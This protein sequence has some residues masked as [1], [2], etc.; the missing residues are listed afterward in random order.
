MELKHLRDQGH[1]IVFISHKLNEIKELCDRLTVLRLGK[2]VGKAIV[3]DVT[4]QDISRMMVGRD[5]VLKVE[6]EPAKPGAPVLK[7]KD[8]NIVSENGKKIVDDVSF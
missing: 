5:V 6:K 1:T 3:A 7:I 2:S 4:E 8:L